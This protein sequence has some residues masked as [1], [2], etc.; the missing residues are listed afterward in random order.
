MSLV[1]MHLLLNHVP[2]IGLFFV[3]LILFVALW[4]R[5]DDMAKVGLAALAG[6]AVVAAVVFLTGEPAEEAVE[7]V[8][9]IAESAIHDHEEAAEAALISISVAGVLALGMLARYWRRQVPRWVGSGMLLM[10]L[11]A[12]GVMAWT[13]NLGGQIRHTEIGRGIPTG[14]VPD[15]D[16]R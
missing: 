6:L 12:T 11:A 8:S 1:H 5:N 7:R 10:T 3:L 15:H 13:A 4:R 14:V 2:M 16:D 9:G